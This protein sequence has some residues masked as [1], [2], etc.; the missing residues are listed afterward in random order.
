MKNRET[1]QQGK[2]GKRGTE[3]QRHKGN[4]S[5]NQGTGGQVDRKTEE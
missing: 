1:E 3:K 5:R 4:G 2:Q